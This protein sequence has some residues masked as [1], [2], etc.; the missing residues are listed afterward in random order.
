MRYLVLILL[1]AATTL[2][3]CSKKE[4]CW[5][6]VLVFYDDYVV[7]YRDS[8]I[9][10]KTQADITALK[11]RTFDATDMGYDVYQVKNCSRIRK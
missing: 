7:S 5:G 8:M 2:T 4:R 3:A 9:C 1:L 11:R 6:C 10:D